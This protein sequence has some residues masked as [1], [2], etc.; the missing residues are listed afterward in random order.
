MHAFL[1]SADYFQ[2]QLF[3]KMISGIRPECKSV[4]IS[5]DQ[6]QTRHLIW[7]DLVP[8][9]AKAI[10]RRPDTGGQKS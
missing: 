3:R 1:S 9:F 2:N 6:D 8:N 7:P 4:L 10:T 5:L